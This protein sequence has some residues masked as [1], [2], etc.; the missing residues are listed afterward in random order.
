MVLG[1]GSIQALEIVPLFGFNFMLRCPRPL[2]IVSSLYNAVRHPTDGTHVADLG[3]LLGGPA[4]TSLLLKMFTS[5]QDGRE[6]MKERPVISTEVMNKHT[7]G[8]PRGSLGYEYLAFMDRHQISADTR[9]PIRWMDPKDPRSYVLLR[10]RQVHDFWHVLAG[11]MPIS[12][13]GELSLKW[14]EFF[15]TGLPMTFLAGSFAPIFLLDAESRTF[16]WNVALPWAVRNAPPH[17]AF[18]LGI[19]FEKYMHIQ[20]AELRQK[21]GIIPFPIDKFP[22][23]N[24]AGY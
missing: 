24:G 1:L 12:I 19:Y 4:S 17:A 6:I 13:I 16:V 3:E 11:N 22:N 20:I 8:C 7:E 2:A 5:D 10:Y 21:W 14:M 15:Q 9:A 18:L 23:S